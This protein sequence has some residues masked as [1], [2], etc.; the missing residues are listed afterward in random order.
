MLS[1]KCGLTQSLAYTPYT[2]CR[3][4]EILDNPLQN[5]YIVYC[6]CI[7]YLCVIVN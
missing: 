5:M 4:C 2:V 7:W 1:T 3:D 6:S